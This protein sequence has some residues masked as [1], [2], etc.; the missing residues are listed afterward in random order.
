MNPLFIVGVLSKGLQTVMLLSTY[1]QIVKAIITCCGIMFIYNYLRALTET[2]AWYLYAMWYGLNF[3]I[4]IPDGM[5]NFTNST[6]FRPVSRL[7]YRFV[8][9]FSNFELILMGALLFSWIVIIFLY[10][11]KESPP[12]PESA[13]WQGIWRGLGKILKARG[14]AVSWDFTLEHLWDP[15]KLSQYLSQGQR[16]LHN[17]KEVQLIWGLACAYRALY[18]T[19]L[20]RESF[21]AEVQAKVENLQVK[22]DQ[23]QETPVTISVAPVEGKKWKRVS[24]RLERK[25]EEAEEEEEEDPGEGPS[26]EPP[27]SRKA[28]GKTKR[29]AEETDDEDILITTRRPLK[30]T[31]IQG[32]RKEFTRGPNETIVSWLV[33]CWDRGA[34]SLFLDGNEARQ[35]GAI[36]RDP[37]IDRGIGRCLDESAS[38]W[39]RVLIAVKERY[40]FK[41]GL[42][43]VMKRWDTVEKGIQYLREMAVVEMLFDPNF[44][45]NHPR[46]ERDPERVRTTP[47]IWQRLITTAPDRY[48]GT[49]LSANDRYR[50]QER[51]PLVFEL[52]LTLQNY[53]QQLPPT[54]AS[55]AAI[56]QVTNQLNEMQEQISQL[57]NRDKPVPVSEAPSEDQDNQKSLLKELIKLM[58]ILTNDDEP[59]YSWAPSKISAIK[60]KRFPA[61]VRNNTS[62]IALWRYLRDHGEDMRKWHDQATPVLRARVKELQSRSITSAVAPLITGNE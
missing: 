19:I 11:G 12:E 23:L 5:A 60:S 27:P 42:K 6:T 1:W 37:A 56:S 39:E 50:E 55:I 35:L 30:M 26:S 15:E 40:R 57:I 31:E 24:T 51:I 53:E 9:R 14:P 61:P 2:P 38:L 8:R 10:K 48:A 32:S 33:R 41:D 28:K 49:L 20:E 13:D 22:S 45:P 36:A 52:I 18:N 46:Q 17:S 25:K 7:P 43:P 47:E 29:H 62:R 16:G 58:R 44:V 59:P 4:H 3:D 54:H 21:R 34:N